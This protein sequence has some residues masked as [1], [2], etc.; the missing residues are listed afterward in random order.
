MMMKITLIR[1]ASTDTHQ[2]Y[3]TLAVFDDICGNPIQLAP[4]S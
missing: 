4:T 1:V 2:E 3:V